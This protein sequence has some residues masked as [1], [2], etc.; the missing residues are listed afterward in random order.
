MPS[1]VFPVPDLGEGLP[2]V[3]ILEWLVAEG[4]EVA[5]GA[6]IVEVETLKGSV[7]IPS[8][9]A[10]KVRELHGAEGDTIP[11]GEPLIT[12]DTA[13]EAGIVGAV[14]REERPTRRV[15]LKPPGSS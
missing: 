10:G 6:P 3:T 8:P 9:A 14:P 12:Y 11:V 5:L 2:D 15:R 1:V 7:E 4:E 13:E